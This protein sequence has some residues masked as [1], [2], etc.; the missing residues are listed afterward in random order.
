MKITN[1]GY[2]SARGNLAERAA[3]A[4]NSAPTLIIKRASTGSSA[5]RLVKAAPTALLMLIAPAA[6]R[7]E[8]PP[9]LVVTG[10]DHRGSPDARTFRLMSRTTSVEL[11]RSWRYIYPI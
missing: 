4:N 10:R 7:P 8:L 3:N 5:R 6:A 11:V 2:K 9:L 1:T